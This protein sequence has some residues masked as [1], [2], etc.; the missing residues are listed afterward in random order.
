MK[1]L[2]EVDEAKALM[3]E[4][5]SWS[6][7]KWLKE[8]KRVRKAA[9]KANN[10]LW[11]LQK[12]VRDSWPDELK[13]AYAELDG[14]GGRSQHKAMARTASNE[15]KLLVQKVKQADDEAYQAH[16]DAEEVF[17]KADKRLSTSLAREGC[18]QAIRSWELYEEAILKA[19]AAPVLRPKI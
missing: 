4:A 10:Y 7:M 14:G 6:V 9:D 3:K 2:P 11:A 18:R 15:I 12:A 19:E 5:V 1:K 13:T 17:D 16:L 8:K